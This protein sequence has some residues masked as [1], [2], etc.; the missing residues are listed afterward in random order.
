MCFPSGKI[1]ESMNMGRQNAEWTVVPPRAAAAIPVHEHDST[2]RLGTLQQTH[3]KHT[4]L[5]EIT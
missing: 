2:T 3:C 5:S 4:A 1:S